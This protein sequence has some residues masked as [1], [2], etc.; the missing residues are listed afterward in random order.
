MGICNIP[1]VTVTTWSSRNVVLAGPTYRQ[2]FQ[3][4]LDA[5]KNKDIASII[6][7]PGM[8]KTTILKKLQENVEHSFYLDLASK[9]EIEDEFWSKVDG[10]KLK[11]LVLPLLSQNKK[12][13]GYSFFKK[14]FG[15]KFEDWLE[16]SCGKFDDAELKIYCLSYE[17]NFDGMLKLISDLKKFQ[18]ITLLIDEIR[19]NHISKIHRLIN[20][21]LGIPVIMAIPTD[22]YSKITDLAIRRRLDES[23]IS[24]DS[25]LTS[26][27]IKEI[28]DAYCHPIVDDLFPIVLSMWNGRELNT[29]SSIL[30]F[31]KNDIEKI[32]KECNEDLSC[33][34]EKLKNSHTLKNPEEDSRNLEKMIRDMLNSLSKELDIS[35]VHPRGKRIE[36]KG[37]YIVAGLFFIK[38]NVAYVGLVKLMSDDKDHDEEVELLSQLEKVEHEKKEYIVGNKFVITNSQNLKTN[39]VNKIEISTIEAIRILQGDAD[40]LEEKVKAFNTMFNVQKSTVEI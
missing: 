18:D 27:D 38:D 7:Q 39:N 19:E 35:Y 23:R 10:F 1:K 30:Q 2:Y 22:S 6:G 4:A 15:V 20:S 12:K 31:I 36:I 28:I 40:I 17:R 14:L 25:A 33:I 34:K 29:V 26:Q 5:I 32:E 9:A 3:K 24:L 16:K 11:E 21:G 13:Y 8:G 37:K